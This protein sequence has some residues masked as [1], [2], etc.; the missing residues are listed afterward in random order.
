M[1]VGTVAERL[2]E[3]KR[4]RLNELNEE[5][6][7]VRNEMSLLFAPHQTPKYKFK[8]SWHGSPESRKY[9]DD[10]EPKLNKLRDERK[11]LLAFNSSEYSTDQ[12]PVYRWGRGD[13]ITDRPWTVKYYFDNDLDRLRSTFYHEIGHQIH[14]LYKR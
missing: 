14:Q 8:S 11:A 3:P 2:S 7:S 5:I 13:K 4:R 1:K 10:L 12:V 9:Y 6:V